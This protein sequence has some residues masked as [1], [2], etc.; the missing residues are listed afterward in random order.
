[1]LR[2]GEFRLS[3]DER[4]LW[5]NQNELRLTPK[6]ME[7]LLYL[8]TRP[9][10]VVSKEDIF[11]ALWPNTF[12]GDHALTVQ[13][14]EVRKVL[15]EG[16]G[17]HEFIETR[18]RRGY[19][20]VPEPVTS[21]D[22]APRAATPESA[23]ALPGGS[24]ETKYAR[25]G[26]VNIAYQVIGD[27]PVDVV[28]VMGWVS[29]LEY[30]WT[31]PHFAAFLRRL[32]TFS[33]LILFDKRGTGLSDRVPT[34]QLP[35]LEER[36]DDL[37]AVMDAAGAASAVIVSVSE[38]GPMSALFAATYPE[39]TLAL[40][41]I[42]T[43]AK[44]IQDETY[45]WGPTAEQRAAFLELIRNQW[46]GPIG[47]EDRAPSLA[48]DPA[49][50]NWWAAYLRMG[51]SPA[52][53]VALTRMNAEIDVRHVLKAVRVP[54]LVLH[55]TGDRTLLVQEGR[56]VAEQI[57]GARFIEL[58]GND[59]LPFAGNQHEILDEIEDFV[60]S[61]SHARD[62][63]RVLATV[64]YAAFAEAGETG[65]S[66]QAALEEGMR[67]ELEWFRGAARRARPSHLIATFDGPARAVRCASALLRHAA[68]LG[69]RMRA[70]LHTGECD[71]LD[72]NAVGGAAVEVAESI[73]RQ[74]TTDGDILA[75]STVRD[76]V[77]GSGIQFE[78]AG[79]LQLEWKLYRAAGPRR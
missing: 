32:A 67:Q 21:I 6:A 10:E 9:G 54:T 77:A 12:V 1:M 61:V 22:P 28:F 63:E 19:R 60:A 73:L 40:V 14:R 34:N 38:G 8:A 25:S 3:P 15:T 29:H 57:P 41:M 69:Y 49:F 27:G 4:R 66:S 43:Y 18:H 65:A 31:E 47:I 46:G 74:R 64:L 5:K 13:I 35:T 45:P 70:A 2:F 62:P 59:H 53:A 16:N 48:A 44:R 42:G 68:R 79:A 33:R 24:P 7:L 37:R 71:L 20:F 52:T 23:P 78:E 75:S 50:R 72:G 17:A 36:M 76:L 56:Y 26:D 11:K 39:K 30:F 58:P 55:R 51:A